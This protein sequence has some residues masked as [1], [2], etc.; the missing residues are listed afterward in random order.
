V[1]LALFAALTLV[2]TF[3]QAQTLVLNGIPTSKVQSSSGTTE[4]EVLPQAKQLE[5]RVLITKQGGNYF[6]ASRGN[7]ALVY[8]MSGVVHIFIE[9]GGAGYIEVIDQNTL[10]ESMRS[11]DK[12]RVLYQEH[13]RSMLSSIT[14]WGGSD[15][16]AP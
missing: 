13:I 5:A 8:R 14:Y 9:A 1:R 4:R 16:F 7:R 2:A 11:N 6:W 15:A 3:A 10:P 12:P